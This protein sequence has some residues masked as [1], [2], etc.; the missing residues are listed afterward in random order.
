MGSR[1]LEAMKHN[2]QDVM[3]TASMIIAQIL[4]DELEDFR[5]KHI[6]KET[7]PELDDLI[8]N[9]IYNALFSL[10][11]SDIDNSCLSNITDAMVKIP[12]YWEAPQL[13]SDLAQSL[14]KLSEDKVIFKSA[15]LN[16][17]FKMKNIY[18]LPHIP[19]FRIK[20]SYEFNGVDYNDGKKHLAKIRS[21]LGN[22][23]YV[24]D[25]GLEGYIYM[26]T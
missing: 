5:I 26:P 25:P 13:H 6:P 10:V 24:Y 14:V 22:E 19:C 7:T 17:Q 16:E 2:D 4:K 3:K 20:G 1:F 23:Q 12:S 18:R 8:K 21:Q 11:N 9:G 15:F